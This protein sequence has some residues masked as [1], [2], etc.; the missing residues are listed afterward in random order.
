M[1]AEEDVEDLLDDLAEYDDTETMLEELGEE[2]D[3]DGLADTGEVF[4]DD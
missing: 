1:T 4:D 2:V 3:L